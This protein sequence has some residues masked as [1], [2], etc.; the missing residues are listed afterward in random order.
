MGTATYFSPEQAQGAQPDP[1]SDLY[2]LGI[3]MY[4][5]VAGRPPF[6]GEN[7]VEHRLQAG[8][9]PAAAAQPDRRR[10]APAVRGDRRQAAGQGPEAA[11]PDR[12]RAARRPAPVPQRRAG[13]GARVGRRRLA[14]AHR[15]RAGHG[16][17]DHRHG[18]IGADARRR[19]ARACRWPPPRWR[20]PPPSRA[21]PA[22]R[23]A[24]RR[25]PATTRTATRAPA[26]TRWPRSSPSSPSSS[27]A[28]CCS[29]RST[30]TTPRPSAITLDDY[31]NLPPRRRSSP[32]STALD[33]TYEVGRRGEPGR[34]R[35]LRPPH[36]PAG[37]HAR[38]RRAGDQAVLQPD[39]GA[40]A[41][42][43]T[44]PARP[45]EEAQR[46]PRR[47]RVRDRRGDARRT[48][49]DSGL[50]IRTDP[51]GGERGQAGH[52]DHARR[53]RRARA[54]RRSR[55]ASSAIR[56][57]SPRELLDSEP[58]GFEVTSPEARATPDRRPAP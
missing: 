4:E 46:H 49:L 45:L 12:R 27:A 33:L 23:R 58:Y 20:R 54:D 26:G 25:P 53:L 7:P 31:V 38:R 55:P 57:T 34:R 5:M 52:R 35:G 36:R 42:S 17:A 56:S 16:A 15:R 44:S 48:T 3:V 6:T 41:R 24:P 2:S 22:T 10:R 9:R 51:A 39:Q 30:R 43:P 8:P 37:R 14:G 28:C 1:R 21:W 19:P 47:R 29:R 13:A 18:V 32:T 40:G 11:L 50:V